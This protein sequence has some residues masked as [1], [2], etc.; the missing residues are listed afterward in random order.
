[1]T[2]SNF[3][4]SIS[5]NP[6]HIINEILASKC[7]V[8]DFFENQHEI[9]YCIT[10]RSKEEVDEYG[11][12]QTNLDLAIEVCRKIKNNGIDPS[13]IIEPTCGKGNFIIA[14]LMVFDNIKAVY[15]IEI[16]KPYI[17]DTK[18]QI[19]QFYLNHNNDNI[20]DFHIYHENIFDFDLKRLQKELSHEDI[21][22][23]GNPPWVTNDRLGKLNSSN[24]PQKYNFKKHKGLDSITGK[25]NFDI[26]E[27]IIIQLIKTFCN[28]KT[29][30][31]FLLKNSVIKNIV[32]EQYFAEYPIVSMNQYRIDAK[33]EFNVSV[34]A[35]LLCMTFG[36]GYTLKCCTF[37]FYTGETSGSYGWL[38]NKFVSN[39]E[40][41]R[42]TRF[43]EG[44]SQLTW[45]SG[46]KHDCAKVME[47]EQVDGLLKNGLN[48]TVNIESGIL[49]PLAKSSDLQ[50]KDKLTKRKKY[51]I[52]T[53]RHTS[54]ETSII[55]HKY[56]RAYNYLESHSEWFD[57]RG[58]RI[59]KSRPKFCIFGIGKYSFT[60]YKVAV[61]G[62]YKEP[63]FRLLTPVDDKP[64]MV[65]DTCYIIGFEDLKP[66]KITCMILNNELVLDFIRS[67]M[68]YDAKRSITKDLLM[69]IDIVKAAM[70]I[71]AE[72]LAITQKEFN[73]Y[74][75]YLNKDMNISQET[76]F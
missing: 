4:D 28:D 52:I 16:Y 44:K 7:G 11:D 14:A 38:E 53:Q 15:G 74:L 25:G 71:G 55:K 32:H 23:I 35:S 34:D 64:I 10:Q 73:E 26:S 47:L 46:I 61:S 63:V 57:K 2:A 29:H 24:I 18:Y 45:W 39:I 31:A 68:F 50:P 27:Y 59:Y 37:D 56:P 5:N 60:Q 9:S 51:V 36:K 49:Y 40:K 8:N 22:I 65:D 67:I 12:W 33:K 54:E 72:K 21:L 17:D 1:M 75:N 19:L 62:L 3:I 13:V 76:L 48:E 70:H 58:S 41:Y 43:I 20:P 69:R 6:I 42:I 30:M 66:A